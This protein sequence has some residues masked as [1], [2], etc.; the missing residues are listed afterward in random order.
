MEVEDVEMIGDVVQLNFMLENLVN[1]ALSYH[2][3]GWMELHIYREGAF[4]RFDFIDRRRT[5]TQDEL[6]LLFYPHL[7]KMKKDGEDRLKG[8]E[9][10]VCKQVVREHDEYAG[11][12]GCR[13][14]AQQVDGGG[15]MVWFTIPSL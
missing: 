15:F 13:I 2:E 1:E 3:P 9:Y 6:N 10:L 5:F 14:N 7:A 11:M 12:R 4:V 8:T